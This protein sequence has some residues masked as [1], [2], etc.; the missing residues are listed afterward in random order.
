MSKIVF[1]GDQ[2]GKVWQKQLIF[3]QYVPFDVAE[4]DESGQASC[5]LLPLPPPPPLVTS[6][7]GH[8]IAS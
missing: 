8:T 6:H 4:D 2:L 5:A 1:P 3:V 7:Q